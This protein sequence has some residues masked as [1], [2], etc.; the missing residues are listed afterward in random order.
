MKCKCGNDKFYA[1]QRVYMDVIVDE[2]G[3]FIEDAGDTAEESISQSEAPYGTFVCTK[4][5]E[6]YEDE[7]FFKEKISKTC[8]NCVNFDRYKNE[9]DGYGGCDVLCYTKHEDQDASDCDDFKE[10]IS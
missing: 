2:T 7:E 4:C 10:G 9:D 6:C 3:E 5:G 8:G 1:T